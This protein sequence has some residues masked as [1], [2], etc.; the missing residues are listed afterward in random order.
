MISKITTQLKSGDGRALDT[1]FHVKIALYRAIE[2][3]TR[4][5]V[6]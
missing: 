6:R 4:G 2:Y 5:L 1:G 3:N